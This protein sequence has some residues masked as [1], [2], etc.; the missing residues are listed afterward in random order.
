MSEPD[1]L[2]P[3]ST[4]AMRRKELTR[5][6]VRHVVAYYGGINPLKWPSDFLVDYAKALRKVGP[7][8]NGW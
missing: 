7:P 1:R 5:A 4:P 8:R 6:L 2:F 3:R